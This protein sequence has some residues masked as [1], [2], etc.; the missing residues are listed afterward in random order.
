MGIR[1]RVTEE[2]KAAMI[3]K[4]KDRLEALRLIR[5]EMLKAEKETGAPPD[6]ARQIAILQ[7]MLKQRQ[8]SI[9]QYEKG[10]RAELA[11]QERREAAVIQEYL[12]QGLS[13]EEIRA[14]I[15]EV[16]AGAGGADAS[17]M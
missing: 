14:A 6:D 3:A 9:E 8:E 15:D 13:E 5:A 16:I 12:P 7:K 11:E 4:E 2:M 17:Q 1:E 10:G